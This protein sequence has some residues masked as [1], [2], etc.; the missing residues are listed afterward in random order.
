MTETRTL[1]RRDVTSVPVD[2]KLGATVIYSGPSMTYECV[3][4]HR[5]EVKKKGKIEGKDGSD[6]R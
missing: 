6:T 4:V 1:E 3:K 5:R 2:R